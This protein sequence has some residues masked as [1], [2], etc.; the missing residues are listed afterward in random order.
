MNTA[1][2][3]MLKHAGAEEH[4]NEF[5]N[6]RLTPLLS[7]FNFFQLIFFN[8]KKLKNKKDISG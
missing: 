7:P 2:V 8:R 5:F 4:L 3:I 1:Q 6:S